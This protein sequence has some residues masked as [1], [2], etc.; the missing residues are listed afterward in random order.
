MLVLHQRH[1]PLTEELSSHAPHPRPAHPRPL[2]RFGASPGHAL[3]RGPR[4]PGGRPVG[5]SLLGRC[6]RSGGL[7]GLGGHGPGGGARGRLGGL[8]RR[9]PQGPKPGP[10]PA[11][12]GP[13]TPG[14]PAPPTMAAAATRARIGSPGVS[15]TSPAACISL[16]VT[17]ST[18]GARLDGQLPDQLKRITSTVGQDAPATSRPGRFF[19]EHAV[20]RGRSFLL[21]PPEENIGS[22]AFVAVGQDVL[23]ITLQ[24]EVRLFIARGF[25]G[26]SPCG[27][28]G[29]PMAV[30]TPF[31][32]DVGTV[33]GTCCRSWRAHPTGRR[34]R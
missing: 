26:P 11:R 27:F 6:R 12:G 34:R 2:P 23:R 21:L 10:P 28:F 24:V 31:G 5:H 19:D 14:P 13:A 29:L 17:R 33:I 20:P 4:P 1:R 30:D 9:P 25:D 15:L 32:D 22:E 8:G 16:M 7:P 18:L 3:R